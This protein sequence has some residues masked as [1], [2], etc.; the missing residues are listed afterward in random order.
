M[1]E[2]RF[3]GMQAHTE[4]HKHKP[5][6]K[7]VLLDTLHARHDVSEYTQNILNRCKC[8]GQIFSRD[9]YQLQYLRH[10]HTYCYWFIGGTNV[11]PE[12][13]LDRAED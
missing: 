3:L 8:T 4:M 6:H 10:T 5:A 12:A 9:G 11:R 7:S 13:F 2:K 1:A